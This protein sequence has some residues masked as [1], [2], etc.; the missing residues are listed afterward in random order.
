MKIFYFTFFCRICQ[1][2]REMILQTEITL[3]NIVKR[4]ALMRQTSDLVKF[5]S[6]FVKF[7]LSISSIENLN[8]FQFNFEYNS[9]IYENFEHH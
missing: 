1:N 3:Q 7:C 8:I 2:M 5:S 6:Y 9:L 4:S